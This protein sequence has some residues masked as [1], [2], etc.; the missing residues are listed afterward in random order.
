MVKKKKWIFKWTKIRPSSLKN[1]PPRSCYDDN[2]GPRSLESQIISFEDEKL[3]LVR[4]R[5][6][7]E[8]EDLGIKNDIKN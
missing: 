7:K 3:L 1:K 6:I 2:R 8:F 4:S 5:L